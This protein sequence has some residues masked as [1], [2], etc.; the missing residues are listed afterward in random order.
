[1]VYLIKT[2]GFNPCRP[3]INY[4]IK[5]QARNAAQN[6]ARKRGIALKTVNEELI[7]IDMHDAYQRGNL[8]SGRYYRHYNKQTANTVSDLPMELA[9]Y[10]PSVALLSSITGT[11]APTERQSSLA[12]IV[13]LQLV[14]F[15]VL[16]IFLTTMLCFAWVYL[17]D[18]HEWLAACITVIISIGLIMSYYQLY[19]LVSI[20]RKN[21][22]RASETVV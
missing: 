20:I 2:F 6:E 11:T 8:S 15:T 7:K 19:Q 14:F 17:K 10:A 21:R 18:Q 22:Q 13:L 12:I 1:V 3:C 4:G 5:R 16:V 9:E